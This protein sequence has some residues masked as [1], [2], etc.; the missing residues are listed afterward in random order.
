M[1]STPNPSAMK[2]TAHGTRIKGRVD[3]DVF[4]RPAVGGSERD[5]GK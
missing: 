1:H 2:T 3:V 4:L 5:R